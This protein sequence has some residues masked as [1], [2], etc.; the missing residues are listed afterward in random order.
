M[1]YTAV[2]V[3]VVN[4]F[5]IEPKCICSALLQHTVRNVLRLYL[6]YLWGERQHNRTINAEVSIAVL[7]CEKKSALLP[8]V[9]YSLRKNLHATCKTNAQIS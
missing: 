8:Y 9:G 4:C 6:P 7:A 1:A 2:V 3:V 5:V